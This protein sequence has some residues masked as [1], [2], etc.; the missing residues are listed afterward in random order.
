MEVADVVG[1]RLQR[2]AVAGSELPNEPTAML[3]QIKVTGA[4]VAKLAPI[5]PLLAARR[6]ARRFSWP[7]TPRRQPRSVQSTAKP[8]AGNRG[9]SPGRAARGRSTVF[10]RWQNIRSTS[11]AAEAPKLWE[12][13]AD[14]QRDAVVKFAEAARPFANYLIARRGPSDSA[15]RWARITRDIARLRTEAAR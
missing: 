14:E 5:A 10:G 4:V 7:W 2:T 11:P 12:A 13:A 3:E 9:S 6:P 1:T 15:L 8:R